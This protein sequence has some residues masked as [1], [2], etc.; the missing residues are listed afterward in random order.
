MLP[1]YVT[2]IKIS[3]IGVSAQLQ[4]IA[5]ARRLLLFILYTIKFALFALSMIIVLLVAKILF[6]KITMMQNVLT[7][8]D[9]PQKQTLLAQHAFNVI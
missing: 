2:L 5:N 4:Q 9:K 1:F 7:I 8:K 3:I 6:V